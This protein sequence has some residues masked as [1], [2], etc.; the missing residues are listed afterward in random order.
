MVATWKKK[1]VDALA[2]DIAAA[3]TTAVVRVSN[4][5]SSQFQ[6]I[7]KKLKDEIKLRV[8]KNSIIKLA[9]EKAKLNDLAKHVDNQSAIITTNL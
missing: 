5:P 1:T 6:Q 4:I 2:K 7:R 8:V 3:N 9:L